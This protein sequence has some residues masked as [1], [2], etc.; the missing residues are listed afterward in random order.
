[1]VLFQDELQVPPLQL[2]DRWPIHNQIAPLG[3]LL[4]W[5]KAGNLGRQ[6]IGRDDVSRAQSDGSP[7]RIFQLPNIAGKWI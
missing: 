2:I 7:H 1:L 6:A 3:A 4:N 5:S